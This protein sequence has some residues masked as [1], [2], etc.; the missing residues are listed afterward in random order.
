MEILLRKCRL[1]IPDAIFTPIFQ[2]WYM[3]CLAIGRL[4]KAAP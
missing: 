3:I 4:T 2:D 1:K